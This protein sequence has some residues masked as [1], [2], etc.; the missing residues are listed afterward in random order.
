MAA[1]ERLPRTFRPVGARMVSA[2]AGLALI[3]MVALLWSQLPARVRADFNWL[4]RGTLMVTFLL[5]LVGLHAI[6]R[7]RARAD[8]AGLVVVNGYRRHRYDWAQIV[9][10]SL[11]PHRPWAV[12]DLSDGSTVSVMAVQT[13]DGARA[14][15]L[16]RDLATL[17]SR[18]S[19]PER[20]D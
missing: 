10:V 7:T 19:T 8:T 15:R 12:L 5:M 4:E 1:K 6:F 11:T 2:V 14:T 17:I 3:F 16:T 13:A 18:Q 9:A 20:D